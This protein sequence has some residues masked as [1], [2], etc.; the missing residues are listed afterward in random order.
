MPQ[1][2]NPSSKIFAQPLAIGLGAA[3]LIGY[4]I[5]TGYAIYEKSHRASVERVDASYAVGDNAFFPKSFDAAQ[6]L[7]NFDG[8]SLYFVQGMLAL[9]SSMLKT[10]MDDSNAYAVYK[11]VTA[12]GEEAS[13]VYLKVGA[14]NY[15]KAKRQ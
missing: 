11:L 5:V 6:P 13:F 10:G 15:I 8:H 12:K 9:D 1:V 7:V 14:N 4:A 3:L 2:E